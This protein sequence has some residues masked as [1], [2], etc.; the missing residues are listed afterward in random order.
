MKRVLVLGSTGFMG[1]AL[2]PYLRCEGHE[3]FAPER[4][5]FD[6]R[7]RD[8]MD[9]LIARCAP[10]AVINLAA[11]SSITHDDSNALYEVNAF[12]H[13]N[14]LEAVARLAPT[15][16]VLLASSA[17]VYGQSKN[18]FFSEDDLPAPVNHYAI[19]KL[20]AEQFNFLYSD[21]LVVTATRPFNCVGRGQKP[22]LLLS[23]IV[24]VFRRRAPVLELGELNVTR[25]YV[26]IRDVCAYWSALV[27]SPALP[28][29]VNIGTGIT[30]SLNG[31]LAQLQAMTGHAP[32]II[33]N[34]GLMRPRDIVY[35]RAHMGR[36]TALGC[37][38]KYALADTLAWMLSDEQ[39]E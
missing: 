39:S 25:D 8:S 37:A 23:K 15:T 26:D 36:L 11:I 21:K 28:L 7:R 22:T 13:L 35:Q 3:V 20:M 6:M 24:D 12:G 33:S 14:L 2:V 34:P 17:N 18:E 30:T 10:D 5:T 16:R 19:S 4:N 38:P 32:Q 27:T 29:I 31:I 9:A 1:A